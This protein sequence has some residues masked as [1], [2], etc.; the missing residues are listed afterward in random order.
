MWRVLAIAFV[1][2]SALCSA[3]TAPNK[4]QKGQGQ[5]A[6]PSANQAPPRTQS[7]DKAAPRG[8]GD[9]SSRDTS[10]DASPDTAAPDDSVTEFHS[11]DPHKAQKNVEIGDFYFKRQ[12][13][14]AALSR[15]C[16]ALTYKPSDAIATFRIAEA[17]E[18]SGDV[19]GAQA[20]YQ[21]YLKILPAGPFAAQ[22]KKALDRIK[23]QAEQPN[24]HLAEQHGCEPP[25]K[26]AKS[27][28]EPFDPDRPVLTRNPTS[29]PSGKS[30]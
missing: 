21:A 4:D 7:D 5:S 22:S 23:A 2:A 24:K 27:R 12:N 16:E 6:G 30:Q 18:K 28:P 17:L 20:Y 29:P 19:A 10:L 26:A 13:Y 25:G 15:Y 3:Q 9:S 8:P 1:L 11:W 14:H